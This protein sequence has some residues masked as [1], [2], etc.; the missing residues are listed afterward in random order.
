MFL[1]ASI[2]AIALFVFSGNPHDPE[3]DARKAAR[4]AEEA[5]II[6]WDRVRTAQGR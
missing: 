2:V 6:E 3:A 1:A 5:Q 4:A